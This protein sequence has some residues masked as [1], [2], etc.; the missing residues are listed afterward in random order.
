MTDLLAVSEALERMLKR[1]KPLPA[2]TLPLERA[3]GYVLAEPITSPSDLPPF[4]NSGMDGFA[5]QA[6]LTSKASPENPVTLPLVMDIPAGAAPTAGLEKGQAARIMTGAALPTGADAVIPVELTNHNQRKPGGAMP[7]SVQIFSPIKVGANIR[8]RGQD[9]RAGTVVLETGRKLRAP[10]LG[11]TASLGKPTVRVYRR[12]RVAVLSS[13]DEL[14]SPTEPLRP[15]KIYDSNSITLSALIE[16]SMGEVISLGIVRDD[17]AEIKERLEI[18]IDRSADLILTSAGVSVGAF[19][20]LRQVISE[21]GNLAFW[22]VNMRPGRPLAF[23]SFRGIPLIGLPGNPVSAFVGFE[24]FVRPVLARLAGQAH[25]PRPTIRVT[26]EQPV[27]SD[28]RESYLRAV[29]QEKYG[30]IT[31]TLAGHQGSGNVYALAKANALLIL[32]SGVTSLPAGSE[33]YAWILDEI[34]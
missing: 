11:L 32:P 33:I 21:Y 12:P 15:G 27:E 14:L 31:A 2:E 20:Y 10:D 9:L 22:R 8:T 3:L 6:E 23:G 30:K 4:D 19:D 16:Q 18:A 26:L 24:V 1:F 25:Q 13:G 17:P 28:G 29:L 5:V 34:S 7:A